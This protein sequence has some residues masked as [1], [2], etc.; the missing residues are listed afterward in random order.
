MGNVGDE[1]CLH[2]FGLES[3]INCQSYGVSDG[4]EIIGMLSEVTPETFCRSPVC[5]IT[6]GKFLA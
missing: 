4:V 2:P 1:F 3:F 5:D 6:G